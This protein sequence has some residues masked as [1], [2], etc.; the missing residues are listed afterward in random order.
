MSVLLQCC[1]LT[2]KENFKDPVST[3]WFFI[4]MPQ[5]PW[6][7]LYFK[8]F[9]R[10]VHENSQLFV[11]KQWKMWKGKE[12]TAEL[13]I[14]P[15]EVDEPY[16][17]EGNIKYGLLSLLWFLCFYQVLF[18]QILNFIIAYRKMALLL[19]VWITMNRSPSC[20]R[21]NHCREQKQKHSYM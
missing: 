15:I 10:L 4:E 14:P 11:K 12:P 9:L 18:S 20:R 13:P 21:P 16:Y 3:Q 5:N 2:N 19:V 1:L 17:L 7:V 6:I 8:R